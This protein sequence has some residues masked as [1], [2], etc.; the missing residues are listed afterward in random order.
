M[1]IQAWTPEG[2]PTSLSDTGLSAGELG[3]DRAWDLPRPEGLNQTGVKYA[4]HVGAPMPSCSITAHPARPVF[5]LESSCL[6][7]Y[8]W[9]QPQG[10]AHHSPPTDTRGQEA[11]LA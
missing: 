10:L 2:S 5:G 3:E 8:K 1:R 9:P 4:S 7:R 6:R 11:P